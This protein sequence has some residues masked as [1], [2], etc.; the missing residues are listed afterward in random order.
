MLLVLGAATATAIHPRLAWLWGP[1]KALGH[2]ATTRV[3]QA[4]L[5]T[6]LTA[7]GRVESSHNTIIQCELESL[8][9]RIKGQGMIAG[10][11]STIISIV[12]DGTDVKRGDVLCQLDASDYEEL[13]REQQIVLER[14]KADHKQ[15]E[16]D[17]EV[18]RLAVREFREG[19]MAQ[20]LKQMKASITLA[21][22]DL[23]RSADRLEWT[24]RMRVKG[25]VS[26]SQLSSEEVEFSRATISLANSRRALGVYEQYTTPRIL[27]GLETKVTAAEAN[28][29][30]QDARLERHKFR[31]KNLMT[32]VERCTI[33]APHDGFVIY[34]NDERRGLVI[35]A[36]IRV[37]Q[38]QRLFFLPD[39]S[40]MEVEALLHESVVHQVQPG[41]TAKVRVEGLSDRVLEG[42]V[43]KVAQ[44]A[45]PNLFNDVRYFTAIVKLDAFPKG[46]RPGMS[47][48][49]EIF[50]DRRP[51][52]LTIPA[53]ALA[54]EHGH[55]VC[56]VYVARG[57][58]LERRP[59]KVGRSTRD[60]LEVTEG[61]AV[62][63]EVVLD[64]AGMDPDAVAA[65]TTPHDGGALEPGGTEATDAVH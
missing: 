24:R 45:T 3:R 23:Q 57:E 30:Y 18:A 48:E 6:S 29:R 59:V 65:V 40:R 14:A 35:E 49:V 5:F 41:M 9:V 17:L 42:H 16:L 43:T 56:Y 39:L 20:D 54:V 63:E 50:T 51:G 58:S 21:E 34:A 27:R 11:A 4:D 15:A 46:L 60:V 32:Q 38:K 44:L 25:Y 33:R 62:G 37:H 22:S 13:V 2:V 28:L 36:G 47:A 53:E 10:G 12:P 61:L 8:E 55:E 1:R 64:P 7:S 31:L 26:I 52:A 19:N